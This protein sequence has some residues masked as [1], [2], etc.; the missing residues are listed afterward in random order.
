MR[1]VNIALAAC[2]LISSVGCKSTDETT[3]A[4]RPCDSIDTCTGCALTEEGVCN[5]KGTLAC[6]GSSTRC[7]N[8][9]I[10]TSGALQCG[11]TGCACGVQCGCS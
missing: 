3:P 5:D 6:S 4:L 7:A 8:E 9:C 1:I 11:H 2:L 10:H